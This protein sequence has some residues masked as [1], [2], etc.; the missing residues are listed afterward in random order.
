MVFKFEILHEEKETGARLGKVTTPHGEFMTPA[1]M[2]VG[3]H[4]TVK[5]LTPEDIRSCHAGIILGNSYHLYL[6]PGHKIIEG[7]GG[8]HRFMNWDGPILTDSGGFQ[9]FSLGF[10]T[11]I[12][13]KS[14]RFKSYIDG[15]EH[16]F[17]PKK[18]I[19]VQESLG[20]D[21]IMAFDECIPYPSSY[22]YTKSSTELTARWA[23]ECREVHKGKNALFG[24]V[25]GGMFKELRE[26]SIQDMAAL[27]FDGYALGG[28]SVGEPKKLMYEMMEFSLPMTPKE[29]PRYVMGVG[30]PGDILKAVS[31]GA[32]MFDCVIPTRN[33]RN[34][35]LFTEQGKMV[36][37]NACFQKDSSPI[38]SLCG[39]YTCRHYSRAYLRHLFLSRELLGLRLN[40]IHN[41]FFHIRLMEQIREAIKNDKLL[42]FLDNFKYADSIGENIQ[43][44]G[45]VNS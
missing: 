31:L 42:D 5:T 15:K 9:I 45:R 19:E 4:A 35:G 7:M 13:P 24:I 30:E 11:K 34:G 36:I 18:C 1:F 40:T 10:L 21:I 41:V 39:C 14:V 6:R 37:K 22:E 20:A 16:T 44:R 27:D 23:R 2:P 43:K 3:T 29:K 28:L 38:D 12:F 33:A 32:D 26:K 17:S 25:Q 8:M